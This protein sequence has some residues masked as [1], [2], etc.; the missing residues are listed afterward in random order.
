MPV[1]LTFQP[2]GPRLTYPYSVEEM[3]VG[4]NRLRIRHINRQ[5]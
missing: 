3:A 2:I 4:V 5:L 1:T